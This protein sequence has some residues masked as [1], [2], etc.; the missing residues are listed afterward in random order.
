MI[1]K[2]LFLKYSVYIETQL[3]IYYYVHI[4]KLESL[5]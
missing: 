3:K 1:P 4:W 2:T 5:M